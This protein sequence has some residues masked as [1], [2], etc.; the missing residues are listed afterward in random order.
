MV[1]NIK[2]KIICTG[3]PD[4]FTYGHEK[5]HTVAHGVRQYLPKTKFVH[6]SNGYDLRLWDDERRDKFAELI[7]NST[8][9]INASK[10]CQLGQLQLLNLAYDTAMKHNIKNY[11]IINIGS[12]AEYESEK[13][14]MYSIEKN[15]LKER[16]RQLAHTGFRSAHITISN[17]KEVSGIGK[18]IKMVLDSDP[19]MSMVKIENL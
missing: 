14:Q 2:Q 3:N 15:A 19:F 13:F 9:F 7:R 6:R 18:I 12:I 16:S 4:G 17:L 11:T 8:S 10:I 5:Q 1:D